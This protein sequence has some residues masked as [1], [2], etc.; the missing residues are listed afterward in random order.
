[1]L[2]VVL[3][4]LISIIMEPMEG[5]AAGLAQVGGGGIHC[6]YLAQD[7]NIDFFL[8]IPALSLE[9]TSSPSSLDTSGWN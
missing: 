5:G 2:D 3:E 4:T 7:L 6:R 1:M 9:V 8:L